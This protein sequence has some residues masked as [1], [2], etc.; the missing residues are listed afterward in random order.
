MTCKNGHFF[1]NG[2]GG[3]GYICEKCKKSTSAI[4]SPSFKPKPFPVQ[5][6]PIAVKPSPVLVKPQLVSKLVPAKN[7]TYLSL[8][9]GEIIDRICLGSPP[10]ENESFITSDIIIGIFFLIEFLSPKEKNETLSEEALK[11]WFRNKYNYNLTFTPNKTQFPQKTS[12]ITSQKYL[13]L[14]T[15]YRNPT[16][17]DSKDPIHDG[18][19]LW[20]GRLSIGETRSM[21]KCLD[22]YRM[23]NDATQGFIHRVLSH[24][25]F[26]GTS[27]APGAAGQSGGKGTYEISFTPPLII[28]QNSGKVNS[29]A[30]LVTDTGNLDTAEIIA[31]SR[32]GDKNEVTFARP[33]PGLTSKSETK[34]K[35][36]IE[37]Y[38]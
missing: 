36:T 28:H 7:D 18:F 30:K 15:I 29:A 25:P 9:R 20:A 37:K 21:F 6:S 17:Y 32:D 5:P 12:L 22:R 11:K 38:K 2:P 23:L 19:S 4:P 13:E 24:Q 8:P 27:K 16:D 1:C 26:F 31:F 10:F 33:I 14:S 3:K 34:T 35:V